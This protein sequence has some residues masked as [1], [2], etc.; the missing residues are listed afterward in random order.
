MS[1]PSASDALA[2]IPTVVPTEA[3]SFTALPVPSL[4]ETAPTSCSST[5][6]TPMVKLWTEVEPS[7]E[8]EVTSMVCEVPLS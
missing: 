3:F 4:S 7:A 1:V 6:V 8:V 5:S 2:V